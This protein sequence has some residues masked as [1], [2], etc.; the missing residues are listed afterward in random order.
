M[1]VGALETPQEV[2]RFVKT[3]LD[4]MGFNEALV[5][6]VRS[7]AGGYFLIGEGVPS[8]AP[9]AGRAVK[10]RTDGGAGSTFY[11]WNGSAWTAVA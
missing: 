6:L 5:A 11:V 3:V 10:L 7:L 9:P 2:E 1:S 4:R 8:G